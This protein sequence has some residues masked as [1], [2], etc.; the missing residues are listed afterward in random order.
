MAKDSDVR[1][2]H[3]LVVPIR[4]TPHAPIIFFEWAP[5]SGYA[6]GIVSVTL[7]AS[8]SQIR[9]NGELHQEAVT[10]AYLKCRFRPPLIYA[11]HLIMRYRGLPRPQKSPRWHQRSV[12]TSA[13]RV[14]RQDVQRLAQVKNPACGAVKREAEEDRAR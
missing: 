7:G 6:D 14:P 11:M 3:R 9:P 10:A 1:L 2:P 4:D 13:A 12:R 5:L 8:C